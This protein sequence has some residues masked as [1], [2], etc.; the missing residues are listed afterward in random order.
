MWQDPPG[1]FDDVVW[2]AYVLAHEQ[3]FSGQ[4]VERG[5]VVKVDKDSN[6]Q[7]AP[8]SNL[9]LLEADQMSLDELVERSCG[10]I[11]QVIEDSQR[12]PQT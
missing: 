4:D 7:G 8:I 3:M 6:E 11:L 12:R 1:Y 2:P 10:E 9:I 5:D